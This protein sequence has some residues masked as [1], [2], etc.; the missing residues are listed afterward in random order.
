MKKHLLVLA[1]FLTVSLTTLNA[2]E[3]VSAADKKKAKELKELEPD[4]EIVYDA[5]NRWSIEFGVGQAKGIRPYNDGY[6]SSYP[7]KL[8]GGIQINSFGV[9]ARYMISPKF[10]MKFGLNY[11][12]FTDQDGS[13]SLD[14]E[15]F[16]YRANFEGVV[17]AIRLFNVEESAGRFGLL[18]HGGIQVSRMTSDVLDLSELNGGLIVGFSPQFRITKTISVFGDVSLLNNFRQHFNWDGSNSDVSNNLSGQMASFSFGLSFSFGNEKIHGDWAIIEDPKSKELKELES[19]IGD[20]ETLMNDTD[21][22]GVPDYLDVENNSLPGVAVDTKGR[23]VDLNNN[24]VPDELEKFVDKS[25]T[26]NNNNM[27]VSDGMV[28]KLINDGYIA[29]YFDTNKRVP[30]TASTD[31]IGFVL[32]YLK[33]N[34]G[35]SVDI[36]GYADEIGSTEYNDK[37]SSDRAESVKTILIKAGIEPSRLNILANGVD[38]S[39]DKSSEYARRLVRK[40]IFKI[41]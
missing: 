1:S 32:N 12:K 36:I 34:P 13:G 24:G 15:T 25:I 35:K 23:M 6:Y 19:R 33:T 40:V 26:N 41:K 20:I 27:A 37:L 21:K 29:A 11:D 2:Q 39:V 38:K 9:G 17:N 30:T 18:L 4:Q 16:Q 7:S 14:F 8:F 22:D 10:G 31:N 3:T 28:T 5:Y